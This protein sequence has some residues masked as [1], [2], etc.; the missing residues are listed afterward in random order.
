MKIVVIGGSG[1]IGKKLVNNL[2]QLGH[3]VVAASP[4]LGVNTI[5]GEG[6]AEALNGAQVVVDVS[7]AP[8]WEDQAVLD[9]FVTSNTNLL[10]AE[11]TAGVSHHVALSVVGTERLLQSGYFRAKMAQEELIQNAKV[12]YTIVRATQFFEF[13]GGIADV[14]T[15]GDTVR[16][17][18]ALMQ[19]IVSD[20]VAAAVAH[21]TLAAPA[22]GIVDV[23]GPDQIRMDELVRQFFKATKDPRQVV[24]DANAPYYGSVQVNDQSLVPIGGHPTTTTT[25]HLKDWLSRNYA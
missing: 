1:L 17:P 5:T 10:A 15:Q 21:F 22:N 20:D 25:T 14:A 3:E 16:L 12:P 6:L 9:F 19:P 24:S 2:R 4:S 18:S 13:I 8:S 11:A 7:N 23:A